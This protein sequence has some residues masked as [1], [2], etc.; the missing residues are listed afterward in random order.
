MGRRR[1]TTL[2]GVLVCAGLLIAACGDDDDGGTAEPAE[3]TAGGETET[4]AGSETTA[5]AETTAGEE[6]PEAT[7][8]EA[9]TPEGTEAEPGG[10]AAGGDEGESARGAEELRAALEAT[11]DEPLAAD[12]SLEPFVVGVV[13]IEGD[14]AGSFPEVTE[15]AEAAAQLINERLGGI[16]ADVEAGTPGRPVELVVCRHGADQNE[17]Q[18][19]A[20][21]LAAANPN[22]IVP[23]IDFFTPLMYPIFAPFPVVEMQPIFIAD[24]DQ[25]GV[26]APFGGCA[27][28]FPSSAQMIA[29]IKGHDRLAIIW[30]EN[31]PGTECWQD[32]QERFYQY[33]ADTL[34]GFEFMGFPYTPGEQAG[35]P[36]V[37]QQVSDYLEGAENPAV[38]MGIAAP[39]CASFIQGLRSAGEE[40]AV[41]TSNS[42]DDESVRGLPESAGTFFETPGFI[43]EQ[44]ELYSEF[45]QFMLAERE[46]ALDAYGPQSPRGSFMRSMFS[47]VLFVY[48]VA[49]A[50]LE[51][52]VDIDDREAFREAIATV[53]DFYLLG[54]QPVSCA[55]NVSEYES[56]CQRKTNYSVWDGESYTPDTDITDGYIDVT[57]LLLAVE[58]ALPRQ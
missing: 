16:G 21:E 18:A 30:A 53:E 13:N 9:T 31:A 23:G 45:T 56:I 22:V 10:G 55:G 52:G 32:T 38:F 14:P 57:D 39:D 27:S 54:Y 47:A 7:D 49:N 34:D 8:A 19:C 51:D 11:A 25:P 36:A 42:C 43:V 35:Y 28:A 29:E 50:A 46:A 3:T 15:G 1:Q 33:Y 24:F 40:S 17:A 20:N 37:I 12:D 6:E 48:Q 26:Y 41:Y 4:T 2:M 44:P 5:G 58:E